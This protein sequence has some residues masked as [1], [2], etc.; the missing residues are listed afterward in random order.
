MIPEASL[1]HG[2]SICLKRTSRGPGRAEKKGGRSSGL[3]DRCWRL[4]YRELAVWTA[5]EASLMSTPRL[6]DLIQTSR[7][8]KLKQCRNY[9]NKDDGDR[10]NKQTAVTL[11][12]LSLKNK[13]QKD[14]LVLISWTIVKCFS[15]SS[16]LLSSFWLAVPSE[17]V[18][19]VGMLMY[20]TCVN[21]ALKKKRCW[22]VLLAHT[23]QRELTMHVFVSAWH[24]R[25]IFQP[26]VSWNPYI[27][28]GKEGTRLPTTYIPATLP[29][30]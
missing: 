23:A 6:S 10:N 30:S 26:N 16:P 19:P 28:P 9:N 22:I 17:W 1:V 21:I 18:I 29:F 27:G 14:V 24:L 12:L 20:L 4:R 2:I 15:H 3:R 5:G 7:L 8:V 13:H 25:G 11:W